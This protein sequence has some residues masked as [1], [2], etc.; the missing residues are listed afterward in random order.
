MIKIKTVTMRNFM[1]VGNVTQTVNMNRDELVLVLGENLDLGGDGNRNGVGKSTLCNA[2]SY[3]LYSWPITT[4]KKEHLINKTNDK[5]MV[6]TLE[7]ESS[8]KEYRIVRGLKPRTLEFYEN[9]VSVSS[10]EESD[11]DM[12]QGENKETQ[13]A[14][15]KVIGM[16]HDMFCQIVV[17]NTYTQPFLFQKN[18]EQR[19]IIEQLLGITTLSEKAETLKEDIRMVKEAL[20]K[21][22][23]SIEAKEAAN[24]Q[25]LIQID[26]LDKKN[27]QW[28]ENRESNINAIQSNIERLSVIDIEEEISNF[29]RKVKTDEILSRIKYAEKEV[30]RNNS[31]MDREIQRLQSHRDD[32]V[33]LENKC[34]QTCGTAI[35]GETHEKL[36]TDK[37]ATI[38][39]IENEIFRIDSAT[40]DLT[41]EITILKYEY[42][43]NVPTNWMPTYES[44]ADAHEH[45]NMLKIL[46]Q[47]LES[48]ANEVNPYIDQ[49]DSMRTSA[50]LDIDKSAINEL[51]RIL[52]HQE[53]LLKLLTNK[54]SFIRKTIIEQNLNYLNTRLS[55]YLQSL[56]LPH[57]VYFQNDLSVSISEFG[58]ELSSG[59]LSR[60]EMARLGLG[61]S[62]AFRDVYE[63]L[64][65]R[66]NLMICDEKLENGIDLKGSENA[67]KLLLSMVRENSKDIWVITHREEL[68]PKSMS[69]CKVVK[70]SGFTRFEID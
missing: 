48:K 52:E 42:E 54:D 60:G 59:N 16:T 69:V 29:H 62:F 68:I 20:V 21:E 53:F 40:T 2:I 4:V 23:A 28:K 17:L 67:M 13:R 61:L 33:S 63:S 39:E 9:G 34:C 58:R 7:F 18:S 50:L 1:S 24:K 3:A 70:E 44:L 57:D 22:N 55:Y 49:I 37:I 27:T 38:S 5:N 12:A 65:Q 26:N 56:G 25:I 45:S 66:I 46:Q 41:N 15:E 14:I 36:I 35:H 31:Q 47:Q 11:T 6:V 19:G 51:D 43:K 8:G 10:G 32:L 64:Y 30:R